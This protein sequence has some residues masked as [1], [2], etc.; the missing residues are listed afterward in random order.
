MQS[1]DPTSY[2]HWREPNDI[3]T[4]LVFTL[5]NN[6]MPDSA[7]IAIKEIRFVQHAVYLHIEVHFNVGAFELTTK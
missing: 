1:L 6:D 3:V 4:N 2:K 5:Y 7:A